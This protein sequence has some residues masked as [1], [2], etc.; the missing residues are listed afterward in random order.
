M[1]RMLVYLSNASRQWV[2]SM[3]TTHVTRKILLSAAALALQFT[4]L[5]PS[6]VNAAPAAHLVFSS[7]P[8]AEACSKTEN[9]AYDYTSECVLPAYRWS[10]ISNDADDS[11]FLSSFKLLSTTLAGL[12]FG[13]SGM[14]W[15]ALV[16]ILR[17]GVSATTTV[18]AVVGNPLA[19][20]TAEL[21]GRLVPVSILVLAFTLI[22]AVKGLLT[23]KTNLL[24]GLGRLTLTWAV[25]FLLLYAL[26]DSSQAFVTANP[27]K[28]SEQAVNY[29]GTAAWFGATVN[30]LSARAVAPLTNMSKFDLSKETTGDCQAYIR[31]INQKYSNSAKDNPSAGS[32]IAISDMWVKTYANSY[33]AGSFGP[34]VGKDNLPGFIG[35]HALES[36]NKV[37]PVEQATITNASYSVATGA[38]PVFSD[39]ADKTPGIF[40]PHVHDNQWRKA[41]VAWS[42][43]VYN[44]GAWEVRDSYEFVNNMSD[45]C[46]R[47]MTDT[48]AIPKDDDDDYNNLFIFG[49]KAESRLTENMSFATQAKQVQVDPARSVY[50]AMNGRQGTRFIY[51]LLSVVVALFSA[52]VLGGMALGLVFAVFMSVVLL[53]VG[54]PVALVMTSAGQGKKATPIYKMTISTLMSKALFTVLLAVIIELID[55]FQ[56]IV[57]S[58]PLFALLKALMYGLSPVGA[59][60]VV[61]ILVKKISPNTDIMNPLSATNLAAKAA[62]AGGSGPKKYDKEGNLIPNKFEKNLN[63]MGDMARKTRLG[64]SADAK[65]ARRKGQLDNVA[66]TWKNIKRGASNSPE[67][68]KQRQ[69]IADSK[70]AY[71]ASAKK[72]LEDKLSGTDP[73]SKKYKRLSGKIDGTTKPAKMLQAAND[74]RL[75][76]ALGTPLANYRSASKSV[77]DRLLSRRTADTS[78]GVNELGAPIDPSVIPAAVSPLSESSLTVDEAA[79]ENRDNLNNSIK[80]NF[81]DT[82]DAATDA[83]NARV[84]SLRELET[85]DILTDTERQAISLGVAG[86]NPANARFIATTLRG[87]YVDTQGLTKTRIDA[88]KGM[89]QDDLWDSLIDPVNGFPS[90]E[91]EAQMIDGRPETQAQVATRLQISRRARG[92]ED[93]NGNLVHPLSTLGISKKEIHDFVNGGGTGITAKD[94]VIAKF[95]KGECAQFQAVDHKEETKW[96][97]SARTILSTDVE[98]IKNLGV[99]GKNSKDVQILVAAHTQGATQHMNSKTS[100]RVLEASMKL[101]TTTSD[102]VLAVE[103]VVL[104]TR[105]LLEADLRDYRSLNPK[106]TD[107]AYDIM[108]DELVDKEISSILKLATSPVA[109]GLALGPGVTYALNAAADAMREGFS[110]LTSAANVATNIKIAGV[111]VYSDMQAANTA[112]L[113]Y[114]RVIADLQSTTEVRAKAVAAGDVVASKKAASVIVKY[115]AQLETE[116]ERLVE[117][118]TEE[119]LRETVKLID[120]MSASTSI[121]SDAVILEIEKGIEEARD[122]QARAAQALHEVRNSSSS[123][124]ERDAAT[125][126]IIEILKE[127]QMQ[128]A[129]RKPISIGKSVPAPAGRPITGPGFPSV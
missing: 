124:A 104:E 36:T 106:I 107:T 86:G 67:S 100:A 126:E 122:L 120:V 77:G 18:W 127:T 29:P 17:V 40:G 118:I 14:I 101:A 48:K 44:T 1:T 88:S 34:E 128:V 38:S 102:P 24:I 5:T 25:P 27:G 58:L 71:R 111:P 13:L 57:E 65:Y 75:G 16:G 49:K 53:G 97:Q 79:K 51:A 39:V 105:A 114:R 15:G 47:V 94:A 78:D 89:S 103:R 43:C 82:G 64:A 123:D 26:I 109:S 41:M 60:F 3:S 83:Q 84:A 21:G 20:I 6:S 81:K 69:E 72:R 80:N 112:I 59:F 121:K 9:K 125:L 23:K 108:V 30:D 74:K 85:G 4:L 22:M 66:P 70:R 62:L 55:V 87:D 56:M 35:C 63:K 99:A 42:A 117:H 12:L 2:S 52:W 46:A 110:E 129:A 76:S 116:L 98:A 93:A 96:A 91:R 11:G 10:D 92:G 68:I 19:K 45:Q 119:S 8:A 7:V 50:D 73:D 90:R 61:K 54:V 31:A 32:L 28:T 113:N 115:E 37:P 33:V 95:M